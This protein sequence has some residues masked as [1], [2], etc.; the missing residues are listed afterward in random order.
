[1]SIK[2]LPHTADMRMELEAKSL[3]ELYV[4]AVKGMGE[5]LRKNFCKQTTTFNK[6]AIIET[7]ASD[8]TNLLIDF[9]S[10]VLSISYVEKTIFCMV[11]ILSF[12]KYNI[13][14]EIMGSDIELFDEE[15][16]A[17]TYHEANVHQDNQ[18]RL[19]KTYIIFDI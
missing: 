2:F 3:Q 18:D 10:D 12:S 9:L 5:V 15:I 14:A 4:L 13:K 1:M 17:V 8:N 11:N 16:K 7:S 6:K 19:W